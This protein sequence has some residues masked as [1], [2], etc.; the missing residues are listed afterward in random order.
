MGEAGGYLR[1]TARFGGIDEPMVAVIAAP[2]ALGR[3][4]R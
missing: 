1:L 4:N 3:D 2:V